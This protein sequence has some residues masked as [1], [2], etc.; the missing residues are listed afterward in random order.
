[1]RSISPDRNRRVIIPESHIVV[2][3]KDGGT[4]TLFAKT[5]YPRVP[6]SRLSGPFTKC[7]DDESARSREINWIHHKGVERLVYSGDSFRYKSAH[8]TLTVSVCFT[9]LTKYV[10]KVSSTF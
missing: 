9:P 10:S 5:I 7:K 8:D 4:R 1:M 6:G 2:S 3:E